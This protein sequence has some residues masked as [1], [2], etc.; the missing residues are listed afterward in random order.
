MYV[1]YADGYV[2][3][4]LVPMDSTFGYVFYET[5]NHADDVPNDVEDA[6]DPELLEVLMEARD[7]EF[8]EREAGRTSFYFVRPSGRWLEDDVFAV[9]RVRFLS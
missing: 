5:Y 1:C 6:N 8:K 3:A 4:L 9:C 7:R 2:P